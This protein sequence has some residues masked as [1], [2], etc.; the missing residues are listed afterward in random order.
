MIMDL[1]DANANKGAEK[2]KDNLFIMNFLLPRLD[3]PISLILFGFNATTFHHDAH[4]NETAL[5]N[6]ARI[7][8]TRCTTQSLDLGHKNMLKV[9]P[10]LLYT[11]NVAKEVP[12]F[13]R[14]S[15]C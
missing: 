1:V 2:E 15:V 5:S 3:A 7:H 11:I 14:M 12:P 6:Y 10:V 9:A 8:H 13:H 4:S